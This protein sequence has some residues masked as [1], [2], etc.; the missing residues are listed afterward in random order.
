MVDKID[1][2]AWGLSATLPVGVNAAG[3]STEDS[4]AAATKLGL[5]IGLCAGGETSVQHD[6]F[7]TFF[8]LFYGFV[9]PI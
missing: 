3:T 1:D 8:L 4:A 2:D 6:F 7:H 9:R 5:V